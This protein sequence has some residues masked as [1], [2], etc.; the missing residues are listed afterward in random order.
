MAASRSLVGISNTGSGR[1]HG[2]GGYAV[3]RYARFAT[4][5]HHPPED[6]APNGQLQVNACILAPKKEAFFLPAGGTGFFT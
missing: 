6:P 3:S 5:R 4:Q 2:R 1:H